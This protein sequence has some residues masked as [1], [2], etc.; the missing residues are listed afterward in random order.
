MA[1][2][3]SRS[4]PDGQRHRG[5]ECI[6]GFGDPVRFVAV[7]PVD[8]ILEEGHAVACTLAHGPAG[9]LGEL[10]VAEHDVD[11]IGKCE[12]HFRHPGQH[13][14]GEVHPVE[15]SV[16]VDQFLEHDMVFGGLLQSGEMQDP[17]PV[18]EM[19]VQV[20]ADQQS[21]VTGKL[22]DRSRAV[23]GAQHGFRRGSEELD[24][25]LVIV[26]IDARAAHVVLPPR[27]LK[28]AED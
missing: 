25:S 23:G 10:V 8:R 1:A 19:I 4:G 24:G 3:Q 6:D 22:D 5:D 11:L 18:I 20:A 27:D 2:E 9:E 15:Q 12:D 28:I 21:T 17:V 14:V 7:D 26:E 16:A 13:A